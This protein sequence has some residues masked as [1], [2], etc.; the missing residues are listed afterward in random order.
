[1]GKTFRREKTNNRPLP[2]LN[3]HRDLPDYD[4]LRDEDDPDYE[5]EE[6]YGRAIRAEKQNVGRRENE[7]SH[8]KD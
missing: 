4:N 7:P 1:M 6:F 8:K 5:E 3:N 2:R